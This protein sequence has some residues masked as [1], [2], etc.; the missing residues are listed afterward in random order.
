MP[1]HRSFQL[2]RQVAS[3]AV[4]VDAKDDDAFAFYRKYGFMELP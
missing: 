3:T 2:S 4:I 1:L